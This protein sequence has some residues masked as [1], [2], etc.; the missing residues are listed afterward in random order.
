MTGEGARTLLL[1]WQN[2]TNEYERLL[3]QEH[4]PKGIRAYPET[5][6]KVCA[7]RIALML[8]TYLRTG[9]RRRG[10]GRPPL[11]PTNSAHPELGSSSTSSLTF[12]TTTAPRDRA[13]Q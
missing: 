1:G 3:V 12:R 8:E 10:S 5:E 7:R 9:R 11:A 4:L 2:S 13:L 6:L